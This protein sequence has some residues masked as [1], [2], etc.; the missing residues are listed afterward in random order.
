MEN[1][2][3]E[4]VS[5][6][7]NIMVYHGDVPVCYVGHYQRV[8]FSFEKTWLLASSDWF[9]GKNTGNP[10]MYICIY[11]YIHVYVYVYIYIYMYIYIYIP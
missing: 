11:I 5:F 2:P 10:C 4:I 3:V 1:G 9:K 6:P 8:N 7:M